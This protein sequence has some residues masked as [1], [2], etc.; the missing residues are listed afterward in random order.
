MTPKKIDPLNRQK[1]FLSTQGFFKIYYD[2]EA[3]ENRRE[4]MDKKGVTPKEVMEAGFKSIGIVLKD[5]YVG[6]KYSK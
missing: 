1:K 4:L 2:F 5:R 6:H 3:F